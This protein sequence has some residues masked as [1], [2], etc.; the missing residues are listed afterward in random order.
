MDARA[1]PECFCWSQTESTGK[2]TLEEE[3]MGKYSSPHF[4][5][6]AAAV[7]Q[8]LRDWAVQIVRAF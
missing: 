8:E 3:K 1:P 2:Q 5:G 6:N 4:R 7:A